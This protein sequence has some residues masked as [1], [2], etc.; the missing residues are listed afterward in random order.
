MTHRNLQINL[1]GRVKKVKTKN[2]LISLFEAI[3]NSIHAI[4]D[5]DQVKG[6]IKV[7]IIRDPRQLLLEKEENPPITGFII[8]DNGVGFNNENM[9]SFEESD[10]VYKIKKGG[11]GIGRISWLKFFEKTRIVSIF[12]DQSSIMK[13][14]FFFTKSGIEENGLTKIKEAVEYETK[15]ILKP[16]FSDYENRS[17]KTI[18]DIAI[19]IMEHFMFYLVTNTMPSLKI[20]DGTFS[21]SL[22]NF[23]NET[24]GGVTCHALLVPVL[25]LH[26]KLPEVNT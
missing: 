12:T 24:L 4:E 14:D 18:E 21:I 11:K 13:R 7:E 22:K 17:K 26:F 20:M 23:Y 6:E 25:K 5:R 15:V 1:E 16:I 3:S 10:S 8:T 19:G 9:S 2:F